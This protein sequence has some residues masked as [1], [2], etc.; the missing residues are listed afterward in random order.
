MEE[1][2]MSKLI[3]SLLLIATVV[4]GTVAVVANKEK[5]D[6]ISLSKDEAICVFNMQ[7]RYK[8]IRP[9]DPQEAKLRGELSNFLRGEILWAETIKALAKMKEE[10]EEDRR[11]EERY[12]E[13]QDYLDM[14][15]WL[16]QQGIHR[17][18]S[19]RVISAPIS[20]EKEVTAVLLHRQERLEHAGVRFWFRPNQE[21]HSETYKSHKMTK[22]SAPPWRTFETEEDYSFSDEEWCMI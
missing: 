16:R 19:P 21:K 10:E 3:T 17:V 18:G 2:T 7:T 14:N 20:L 4:C 8:K 12:E 11:A 1:I 5:K 22:R 9:L 6:S 15:S 13:Y